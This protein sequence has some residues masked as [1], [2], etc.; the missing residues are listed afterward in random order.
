MPAPSGLVLQ[1]IG[2][3]TFELLN[4]TGFS[5]LQ[6]AEA[7]GMQLV[8]PPAR[9]CTDNGVMVGWAGVER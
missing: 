1:N 4:G 5:V 8:V 9:W 6:V 3:S 7:S 2:I